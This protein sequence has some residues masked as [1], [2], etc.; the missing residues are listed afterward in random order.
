MR[1]EL[2]DGVDPVE[3]ERE[4][5]RAAADPPVIPGRPVMNAVAR[6]ILG[7]ALLRQGRFTEA[8]PEL[9]AGIAGDSR[10][11]P[12]WGM[13]GMALLGTGDRQGA[14]AAFVEL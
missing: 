8:V 11:A 6:A 14:R 9:R 13:L 1:G 7:G 3:A 10:L 5:R 4:A 12:A 2:G